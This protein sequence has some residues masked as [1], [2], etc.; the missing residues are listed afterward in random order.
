MGGICVRGTT[1]QI[2]HYIAVC[3]VGFTPTYWPTALYLYHET[4]LWPPVHLILLI[5]DN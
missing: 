2:A 3:R 1:I 4:I 5:D